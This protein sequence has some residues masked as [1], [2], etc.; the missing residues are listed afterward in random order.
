ME[1]Y[2]F[3]Q[4]Q[5]IA[6]CGTMREAAERL[7]LS[8]PTLSHNI[9][10][11]ESELGCKLFT[12]AG[13]QLRLTPYGELVLERTREI[14][15]SFKAMLAEVEDMKRREEAT[16][17]IGSYSFIASGFVMS[18]VA[19]EF[20]DSRFVID[21]CPTDALR[22]GLKD[23]RFDVLL[24]T[25]VARDKAFKW[26]K[27]YTEKAFVSVPRD[28]VLAKRE[29][30]TGAD[31]ADLSFSIESG[32]LGY[33]DWFSYILRNAGVPD[34]AVERRP[35]KEHLRVKDAL[36]TCNLITSLIMGFVR[37]SELRAIVPIDEPYA[38]RNIGLLYRADAPEKV[39]AFVKYMKS[40]GAGAFSGNAFIPYF[41]FPDDVSNLH[42]Q[43]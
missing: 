23:G 35:F 39:L 34:G 3:K 1:I 36:P 9:K 6:E 29:S 15:G 27:L 24:A 5:M 28:H 7:F 31:L 20:P 32:L 22:E 11:L 4:F 18:P 43:G 40:N 17:R 33:S 37:T 26:Q 25:D 8:Q 10:K 30:A 14:D 19:A 13:N 42:I 16:L 41:L 38:K 2:Q 21:N 12:R